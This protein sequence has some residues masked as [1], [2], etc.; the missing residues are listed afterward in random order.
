MAE[1]SA[2]EMSTPQLRFGALATLEEE[3]PS[4]SLRP[5]GMNQI[6]DTPRAGDDV[7]SSEKSGDGES[8]EARKTRSWFRP[9]KFSRQH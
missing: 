5:I 6:A 7:S 9:D 1:F 3:D 2:V 4:I 8:R